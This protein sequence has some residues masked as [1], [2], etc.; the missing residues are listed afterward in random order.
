MDHTP[1]PPRRRRALVVGAVAVALSVGGATVATV[2]AV[3]S[4]T[5]VTAGVPDRHGHP[6]GQAS[7]P[8]GTAATAQQQTGVVDIDTV[9]DYGTGEAAGTG[10]VLT[11][12]GEIL[13]NNHVVQGSTS[14]R[15]T[16][17]TSGRTYTGTVV[18][19]DATDDVAVV[20]LQGASGLAPAR[21]ASPAAQAAVGPGTAVAAVGNAGG[22]GGTPSV[23]TGRVVALGRTIT[24]SDETSS[25]SSE[26]LAGM[27]EVDAAVQSGD[28]GGPLYAEGAVIGIDT[29]ASASSG[30][31]YRTAADPQAPG[32]TTGYAIPIG[33]ALQ[34]AQRITSG[35][36]DGTVHQGSPAFLGVQVASG[37][38]DQASDG[39]AAGDGAAIAGV[40]SGS[41]AASAGLGAGDTVTAVDGQAV[42]SAD[43]LSSALAAHHVGDRVRIAW[44]DQADAPHTATVTLAAG[45]A[46]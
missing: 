12:G 28:S 43:Q 4:P 23:A 42:S 46:A 33:K 30:P 21:L 10:I 22:T 25:T 38:A 32:P 6:G 19:T 1:H 31:S 18:G 15:V 39:G 41:P 2:D 34:I 7:Q 5:T 29:A 26:D 8:A 17:V 40:V 13:T 35:V 37:A 45:P 3:A 9:L 11:P 27:I 20:Q 36:D 16:D 14:I 44:T 24:A